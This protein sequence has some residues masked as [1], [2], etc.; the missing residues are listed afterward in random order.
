MSRK[1]SQRES[2]SAGLGGGGAVAGGRRTARSRLA[3]CP[4]ADENRSRKTSQRESQSAGLGGGGSVAGR[5]HSRHGASRIATSP[6]SSRSES[7]WNERKS[8]PTETSD[9]YA[10]QSPASTSAGATPA[11]SSAASATPATQ[12]ATSAES[13][14]FTHR[15][16][17]T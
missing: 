9:R 3:S 2:Q 5:D 4:A 8:C 7:H 1:T 13:P 6:A 14:A 12:S 17:G 11:N 15:S 10:T 16:D